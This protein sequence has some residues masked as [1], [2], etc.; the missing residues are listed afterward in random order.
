[1]ASTPIDL[2]LHTDTR[3]RWQI[4]VEFTLDWIKLIVR[5]FAWVVVN[6][7]S[8]IFSYIRVGRKMKSVKNSKNDL[9][10]IIAI[11]L[12]Q[13]VHIIAFLILLHSMCIHYRTTDSLQLYWNLK[14]VINKLPENVLNTY[15]YVEVRRHF[16]MWQR[17]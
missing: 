13:Y 3:E 8:I 17:T 16:C 2:V 7:F 15:I 14:N 9:N 11:C 6:E 5:V 12:F 4:T 1:M 10:T